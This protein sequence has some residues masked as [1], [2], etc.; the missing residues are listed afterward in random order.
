[1]DAVWQ[2]IK[3]DLLNRKA[4]SFLIICAIVAASA[5]LTLA[6]STVMNLNG[7][8]EKVFNE[9]DGAHLWLFFKPDSVRSMDIQRIESLPDVVA[10]TGR[11]YSYQTTVRLKGARVPVTLWVLPSE[12]PSVNRL[13][14]LDGAYPT[15]GVDEVMASKYIR[16][17][18]K[19]SLGDVIEITTSDGRRVD[20]PITGVAYN[21]TYDIYRSTQPPYIFVTEDLL[22]NL[23]PDKDSWDWSLGLRLA[24]PQ[25]TGAV[26]AQV[27]AMRSAKFVKDHTDWQEV[28]DSAVFNVQLAFIFLSAFSFFAILATVFIVISIVS[29]TVLSQIKQIGVLKAIGFTGG[30]I[31]LLYVGQ[32]T[33][34]SLVGTALGYALGLAL[35]PVPMQTVTASL[36]T[37]FRPAFSPL[38]TI[39]V[40]S[41]VPGVTMLAALAAAARGARINI[42]KAIAVGAEA[43]SRKSFWGARLAERLGAPMVFVL[44]LNDV[45]VKPF[46]A[47]LTGLNLTLGV[48][49]IVFGLA[50]SQTIQVYR[51]N[52]ALLGIVYDATVTRQ[53]SSDSRA[54]RLLEEAPGV[55]AFYAE[56]PLK[57]LTPDGSSVNIRAVEGDLA[58]FPFHITQ[59][60]FFRPNTYEAI[61]GQGLL[62]WLGL[63]VGDPLTLT[64]ED[65]DGPQATWVIVGTYPE[66][67][68][69]G[70]RL[71]V[72]LSSIRPLVKHTDPTS[73]YLKLDPSANPD[74]L[75][76]Y[77][78][79]HQESD[80]NLVLV[81]EAI[82][83]TII[84]LQ[85][86]VF[87]L[88]GILIGIAVVNVLITSLLTAQEKLR[89]VGILKTVGMTPGQ[90]VRMFNTTAGSL[91]VL[92][93][94]I[95]IP[96]G[97]LLTRNLLSLLA[98]SFGFGQI[99]VSISF[100][101][102]LLLV[103]FILIVSVIGSYIP[104]RWAARLYIVRV[105]RQE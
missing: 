10:S 78:A 23:F 64:L 74:Q 39:L 13:L 61:A 2:K 44:G 19:L 54:R 1:M 47:F 57:A 45:F 20:L 82:P 69:A 99:N 33:L 66:P 70:Q 67:A 101:A 62:D 65:E 81:E 8:Y 30:Q 53:E 6:L 75:R 87:M 72:N 24:D 98:G 56:Y 103:P 73:Y 77:L 60:R 28:R 31:L 32:Y 38:L 84:Y 97:V 22:E 76:S 11:Q 89:M 9:L 15:S 17:F 5:L 85:L 37:T 42:I 7:P 18:Y 80:L 16:D 29:S 48:L 3:A 12:T 93:A 88:A 83:S 86:A 58:D 104:A 27:E 46:R 55:Q 68:D 40:F 71:M 92:A 52:P 95:G 14:L 90:V 41:I 43:P 59:G 36:N 4:V 105:L 100:L 51:A 26:L 34:L 96:L 25:S 79:P 91:G 49:G 94:L 63:K 21:P 35:A 50:L 102:A